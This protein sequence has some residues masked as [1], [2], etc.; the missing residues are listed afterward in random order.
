MLPW[1]NSEGEILLCYEDYEG[2]VKVNNVT[3]DKAG[4]KYYDLCVK[5][6]IVAHHRYLKRVYDT[7]EKKISL[8]LLMTLWKILH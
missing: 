3:L 7:H 6:N 5:K 2:E 8:D 4:K 1:R